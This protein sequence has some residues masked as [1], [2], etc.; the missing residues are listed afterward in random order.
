MYKKHDFSVARQRPIKLRL[1]VL[2]AVA[3]HGATQKL[4]FVQIDIK[5]DLCP[6][7]H[8]YAPAPEHFRQEK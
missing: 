8:T 4:Y 1:T 3:R 5:K 2:D 7:F 6:H